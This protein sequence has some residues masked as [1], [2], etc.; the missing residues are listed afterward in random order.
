MLIF[1]CSMRVF[2]AREPVDFRKSHD[3]LYAVVANALEEDPLSGHLFVFFNKRRDRIKLIQYDGSGLWLLYKRL[4]RGVFE[5]VA[6]M[7]GDRA[8]IE[9]DMAK[10]QMLLQGIDL[11]R[12]RIRRHFGARTR[13]RA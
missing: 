2:V 11:R 5:S 4:D 9:I 8:N 1:P 10:L 13:R 3:G 6:H 12:S 7:D